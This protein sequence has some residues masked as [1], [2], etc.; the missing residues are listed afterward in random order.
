VD[1]DCTVTPC[2]TCSLDS[3]CNDP[4]CCEDDDCPDPDF[5]FCSDS[6]VCEGGCRQDSDCIGFDA[7]CDHFYSNCNYCDASDLG[8]A[9]G[10]CQ[11]GC[12]TDVNC[13]TG[14]ECNGLHRCAAGGTL[15]LETIILRT[16]TCSECQGTLLE[17]G[18][19]LNLVGGF[20]INGGTSCLTNDLDH[21]DSIDY[22]DGSTAEFPAIEENRAPLRT[23]FRA[24]L[25][26]EILG[27]T[28]E[29]TA[30]VG[31]WTLE[32][33]QIDFGWSG[34][35]SCKWTCCVDV[36]PLSPADPIASLVDCRKNCLDDLVC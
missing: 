35:A 1:T 18:P 16:A 2:S 21:P 31:E 3:T 29:W 20:N 33:N 4:D 13:I 5:Q 24:Q 23:C 8:I 7:V 22:S 30:G 32:G 19:I 10:T 27:G 6:E 28:V 34:I 26:G 36:V 15:T 9:L 11:P 25:E 17:D 12:S 14:S